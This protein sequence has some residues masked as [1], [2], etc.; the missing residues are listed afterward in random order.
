MTGDNAKA[1]GT[2]CDAFLRKLQEI[3]DYSPTPSDKLRCYFEGR[4]HWIRCGAHLLTLV[5]EAVFESLRAGTREQAQARVDEF[6]NNSHIIFQVENTLSVYMKIRTFVIYIRGSSERRQSWKKFC[7]IYIPLDMNIRWN[8]T[9]LMMLK[10]REHR[11]AF[12]KFARIHRECQPLVPTDQDWLICEQV[13]RCLEVFYNHTLS[14]SGHTPH[15]EQYAGIMW[16]INDICTDIIEHNHPFEDIR[17]DIQKAFRFAREKF[18]GFE[19]DIDKKTL[20]YAAHILHPQ[21]KCQ[22]VRVQYGDEAEE[23]INDTIAWL[24]LRYPSES[25]QNSNPQVANM[26]RHPNIPI[27]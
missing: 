9:Y 24:R 14:M 20:H 12:A 10:A 17:P 27:Y 19:Q 13:E 1:N 26:E 25:R 3:Y 8:S 5:S 18:I 11:E 4:V 22:M 6:E 15:L 2:C 21:V 7:P 23:L 16:G